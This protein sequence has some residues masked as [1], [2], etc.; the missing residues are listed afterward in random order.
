M[1]SKRHRK[2][3]ELMILLAHPPILKLRADERINPAIER[4][5][6][7][8]EVD[9]EAGVVGVLRV[10]EDLDCEGDGEGG[11]EVVARGEGGVGDGVGVADLLAGVVP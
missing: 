7:I 5:R 11:G 3:K 9:I 1:T 2:A 6:L 4:G 8:P 10:A